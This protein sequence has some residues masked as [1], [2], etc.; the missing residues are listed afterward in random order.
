MTQTT[1]VG[2]PPESVRDAF[3]LLRAAPGELPI[4]YL[5]NAATTQKPQQV[6]DALIDYY[7]TS[8]SNVG[9]GF[10]EL[11]MRST[12]CYEPAPAVGQEG[13]GAADPQE[14]VFTRSTT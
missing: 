7:T 10:Y 3:P 1:A 9:R 4:A 5:D 6:L 2:A 14:V 13:I 11:S 8:N 12:H